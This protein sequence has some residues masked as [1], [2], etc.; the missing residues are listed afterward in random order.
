MTGAACM[1]WAG[2]QRLGESWAHWSVVAPDKVDTLHSGEYN[3]DAIDEADERHNRRAMQLS[4]ASNM[5]AQASTC[6]APLVLA[7]DVPS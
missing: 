1:Q 7:V 3:G 2:Q 6:L 5:C 4:F